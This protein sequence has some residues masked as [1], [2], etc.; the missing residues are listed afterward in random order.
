MNLPS[1]SVYFL[2]ILRVLNKLSITVSLP[3]R[4]IKAWGCKEENDEYIIYIEAIM[5]L[6]YDMFPGI[7]ASETNFFVGENYK[8]AC[9]LV[10]FE[11]YKRL[12]VIQKDLLGLS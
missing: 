7:H 6:E 10:C 12:R 11:D 1:V 3:P 2:E 9:F 5:P 8:L 4:I